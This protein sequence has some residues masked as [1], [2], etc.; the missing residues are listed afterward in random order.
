MK[1]W[2]FYDSKYL[3]GESFT[4]YTYEVNRREKCTGIIVKNFFYEIII[5]KMKCTGIILVILI[6]ELKKVLMSLLHLC[7]L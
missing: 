3:D 2:P 6:R 7:E 4:L 5:L 1:L